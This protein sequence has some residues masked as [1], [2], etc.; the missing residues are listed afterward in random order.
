MPTV[1][2]ASQAILLPMR[3]APGAMCSEHEAAILHDIQRKRLVARVHYLVQKGE[4][5]SD[6]IQQ[7]VNEFCAA[8]LAPRA[9]LED[10]DEGETD[11]IFA[12]ALDIARTLIITSMAQQ[13]FPP[14]KGLDAH[15]RALVDGNPTV[16]EQARLRVEA[17]YR[18]AVQAIGDV[19]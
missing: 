12:E 10:D 18:A 11:P 15:A 1:F 8:E 6:Q 5:T 16:V 4:L 19:T 13:G 2:I 3:F 7:K 9:L 17:R 14:P